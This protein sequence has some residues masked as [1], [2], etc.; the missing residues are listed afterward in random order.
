M[1]EAPDCENAHG[2]PPTCR[3]NCV[4]FL[5]DGTLADPLVRGGRSRRLLFGQPALVADYADIHDRQSV[6][7]FLQRLGVRGAGELEERTERVGRD[8]QGR[9]AT[10]IGVDKSQVEMANNR[11]YFVK[12]YLFPFEI[13]SVLPKALQ[14]W[15]SLE[16]EAFRGKGRRSADSSF[17]YPRFT[18]GQA[19]AKWTCDLQ[20]HA[21]LLC[22]DGERRRP[23]EV[24]LEADPDREDA[25]IADIDVDLTFRLEAEGVEFGVEVPLSPALR[26]LERR[27]ATDM[28]DGDLAAL[29][30]EAIEAVKA[31]EATEDDLRRALDA[32]ML[33]GVP[34]ASRVV[35]RTGTG[36]GQRGNLGGWVV[37]ITDVEGPL[38][39]AVGTVEELLEIPDTTTG[40]H[41][42]D[43][44]QDVWERKPAQVESLRGH[45]AAAYRYV[46]DDVGA[47]DLSAAAWNDARAR[48]RLYGRRAWHA[49]G[50]KL[51]VD[52]VRSP[53]VHQFL[54]T[55]RT[56]VASAHLGDTPTQIRRVAHAL[57]VAL[58]SDAVDVEPGTATAE[59]SW[60]RRLRR[61]T[62]TL[63]QLE[64][65]PPLDGITVYDAL[66]LRVDDR[67]HEIQ[68]YVHDAKLM[69]VGDPTDFAVEA[70]EQLVEYFQ[71][72]Q[73]GMEVPRLT[74]ALSAL[75]DESAFLRHLGLL[76]DGL[77]VDLAAPPVELGN[78]SPTQGTSTDESAD[79]RPAIH[80]TPRGQETTPDG[81]YN[82]EAAA[83]SERT[84]PSEG[85]PQPANVGGQPLEPRI[86]SGDPNPTDPDRVG[87][88]PLQ[89]PA[90]PS[91]GRS[92]RSGSERD[93]ADPRSRGARSH[94]EDAGERRRTR[95]PSGGR[96]ADHVRMLVLSRGR[97]AS[98]SN[99]TSP[100]AGSRDDHTARQAVLHYEK[101]CGRR[102][103]EMDALQPGF[104]VLSIE[105]AGRERRI[106]VKGVQ[107]V[108]ER[109]ASVV[110]TAR[111]A[112]DA[113]E[114][115]EDGVEYW[116][117]IVDST[118]TDRPRVFPIR[119]ARDRT[120][121]RYG[122]HAHAWRDAAERPAEATAEGLKDLSLDALDALDAGDLV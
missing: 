44:L 10:L 101:H 67:R 50:S 96:A 46:L 109:E 45:L 14:D 114:N 110:L 19:P 32:V 100:Q 106:E 30:Q 75:N 53:L 38:G 3:A 12:D 61:L 7:A 5:R 15:L 73:R 54:P 77:G 8:G 55:D 68:A 64:D 41:A 17:S 63:S 107:G 34:L 122:F 13:D 84:E 47:E 108:F 20:S 28:A 25:P 93:H 49:I 4:T 29:L 90:R 21:W 37:A 42:L 119:W 103:K 16:H 105:A 97:D 9:V 82:S 87:A 56:A 92:T 112:R 118:E 113:V 116:L 111:Q 22:T 94:Q 65:R 33:H 24:L 74:G 52:D 18:Q 89:P 85:D 120:R 57:D 26:R 88:P 72:G 2:S 35:Q 79:G 43:F 27:G 1:S 51:V 69:L 6:V 23:A 78:E 58:L 31:G 95:T 76:A 81:E 99:E 83:P 39:D 104:D 11:G 59:P 71:L 80:E 70:A 62:A 86:Y 66:A 60:G 40:Q 102:A 98:A 121:L 36:A 48:A 115:E 91:A 117:Y